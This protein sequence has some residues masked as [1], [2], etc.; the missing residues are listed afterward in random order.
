MLFGFLRDGEMFQGT[1]VYCQRKKSSN[2]AIG[3]ELYGQVQSRVRN[4]T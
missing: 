2:L 3:V 4:L 1:A